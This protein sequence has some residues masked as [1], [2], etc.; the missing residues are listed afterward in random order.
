MEKIYGFDK[1]VIFECDG[2][3]SYGA[4]GFMIYNEGDL[5]GLEGDDP[6]YSWGHQMDGSYIE[7]KIHIEEQ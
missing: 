7:P 6:E 4:W 3:R 1:T 5:V 2:T